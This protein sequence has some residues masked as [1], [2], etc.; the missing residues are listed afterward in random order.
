MYGQ[1][2]WSPAGVSWFGSVAKRTVRSGSAS[3]SR[4]AC[5]VALAQRLPC[6]GFVVMVAEGETAVFFGTRVRDTR[7][8]GWAG[9]SL[10]PAHPLRRPEPPDRTRTTWPFPNG[11][12]REYFMSTVRHDGFVYAMFAENN[13]W[14]VHGLHFHQELDKDR[15]NDAK[16][17]C[18]CGYEGTTR[19]WPCPDCKTPTCPRCKE[20]DCIRRVQREATDRCSRCTVIVRTHL[21][22]DGLCDGCR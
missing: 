1:N 20:C 5:A 8:Y 21:L 16:I 3:A 22:I 18:P 19:W 14:G 6:D 2:T 11:D 9:D 12:S 4:S 13:L 15:G 10:P 7:P 17:R